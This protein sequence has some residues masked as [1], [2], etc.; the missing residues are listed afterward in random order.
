MV[1]ILQLRLA[2][3]LVLS[4]A[5][6]SCTLFKVEPYVGVVYDCKA[7]CKVVTDDDIGMIPNRYGFIYVECK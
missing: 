2:L 1:H 4:L 7:K 6:S 3:A 5:I